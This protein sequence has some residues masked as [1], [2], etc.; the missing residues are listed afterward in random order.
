MEGE[1]FKDVQTENGLS[2][3]PASVRNII[4]HRPKERTV[5]MY[6]ND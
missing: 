3:N 5:K 4:I 6:L 2:F 1:G